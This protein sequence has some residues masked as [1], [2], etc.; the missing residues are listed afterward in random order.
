MNDTLQVPIAP[1]ELLDKIS[2][3]QIKA[4]RITD[5]K[6][7]GN[8]RHELELLDKL[9]LKTDRES[10]EITKL[11]EQ[12]KQINEQLWRIE[13]DIR[14]CERNGDFGE[15]FIELARAV[16]KT[17]DQRAAIKKQINQQLGSAIV[18]EKSYQKY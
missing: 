14:D 5:P 3:L 10:S 18:E 11:R 17:N 12:L 2:I 16:Y 7:L 4:E 9:W 1:G 6:A 15:I 13:D 8:V